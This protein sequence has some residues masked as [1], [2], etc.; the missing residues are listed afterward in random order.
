[1][2]I[3]MQGNNLEQLEL[4]VVPTGLQVYITDSNTEFMCEIPLTSVVIQNLITLVVHKDGA[5][6]TVEIPN[7]SIWFCVTDFIFTVNDISILLDH[8]AFAQLTTFLRG[9]RF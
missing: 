9:F 3:K 1:M 8:V 6:Y 5:F 4:S 7:M 2:F